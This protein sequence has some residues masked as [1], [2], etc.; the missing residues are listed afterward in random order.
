MM[1]DRVLAI[2]PGSE[3]SAFVG[4]VPRTRHIIEHGI[5][6][7]LELSRT[8]QGAGHMTVIPIMLSDDAKH[9]YD[10][11]LSIWEMSV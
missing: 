4:Y 10:R 1:T 9:Y 7:N 5:M 2:D 8:L 3:R 6:D 11:L